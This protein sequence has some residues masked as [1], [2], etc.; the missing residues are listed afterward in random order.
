M[1]AL[2]IIPYITA[3]IIVQLMTAFVPS[4]ARLQQEGELGRKKIAQWTRYLTALLAANF[5]HAVN[6]LVGCFEA[7]AKAL[8]G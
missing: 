6:R 1:F 8:Y 7:R 2:G 3:S 4:L 5:Q